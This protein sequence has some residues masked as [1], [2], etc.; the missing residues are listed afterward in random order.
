M[1]VKCVQ[2]HTPASNG[3]F[4]IGV[5]ER[6][7]IEGITRYETYEVTPVNMVSGGGKF[8][9]DNNLCFLVFNDLGKWE[10]YPLDLFEAVESY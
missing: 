9:V 10:T 2:D 6:T 3:F 1:K 5:K 4:G 8:R 7:K